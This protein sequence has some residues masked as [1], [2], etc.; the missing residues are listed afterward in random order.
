MA[1]EVEQKADIVVAGA[2]AVDYACDYEPLDAS[3]SDSSPKLHTS[4]PARITQTIGGVG[5][6]VAK[7]AHLLGS[8]V[9]L[10]SVVG[11]DL[12]GNLAQK[13]LKDSKLQSNKANTIMQHAGGRTAQ[14]M[15]VNDTQKDLVLGMADMD[16]LELNDETNKKLWRSE[17]QRI[18]P[19]CLVVDANWSSEMIH[20]WLS[21][22]R[23]AGA[24]T[25][26]EPVSTAKAVKILHACKIEDPSFSLFPNILVNNISPNEDELTALW[27]AAS[28]PG[29]LF[30]SPKWRS[31]I[32]H[33]E[34]PYSDT[35]RKILERATSPELVDKG[36]P[37]KCIQL[38]PLF[39][40]IH[41]KLGANGVVT[42][43]NLHNAK[44]LEKIK[45]KRNIIARP[46]GPSAVAGVFIQ[47]KKPDQVLSA[48]EIVSVNGAG[49]T[50][51]GAL[52][53][54]RTYKMNQSLSMP[55]I[56]FAQ[57]AARATLKSRESVSSE[58]PALLKSLEAEHQHRSLQGI[59]KGR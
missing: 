48:Q 53:A 7:A 37:Q 52:A 25:H 57:A 19:K 17:L 33:L 44:A 12:A 22:G 15:A 35:Y 2:I 29:G 43:V 1:G 45:D 47:H 10:F 13:V 49:D 40:C 26:F 28:E 6:N 32:D 39:R 55:S 56:Q 14:Y 50:F 4:N 5:Y 8:R 46:E 59:V 36:I 42:A 34:I 41:V 11:D 16:I 27:E 58:L 23:E 21:A 3:T 38:L 20:F 18:S 24:D 9:Q 31:Y 51:L 54:A 30:D